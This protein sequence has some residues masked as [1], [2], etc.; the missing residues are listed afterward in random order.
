MDL[1]NLTKLLL[2]LLSSNLSLNLFVFFYNVK[3]VLSS[4]LN[5]SVL[6]PLFQSLEMSEVEA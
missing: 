1:C 2:G 4:E 6:F 3:L 5:F